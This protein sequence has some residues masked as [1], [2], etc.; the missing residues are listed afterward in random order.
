MQITHE[1]ARRFIQFDAD[2]ALAPEDKAALSVHLKNC[3]DCSTYADEV[4]AVE[5]ILSPVM[6]RQ[7]PF[8]PTPLPIAILTRSKNSKAPASIILTTRTALI[9]MIFL[10]LV[11][12]TWQFMVTSSW[13]P[14][15]LPLGVLPVPT[16][17]IQSTST[18]HVWENC[19]MS[20]YT[21]RE[22]DTLASIAHRF[23][24]SEETIMALNNIETEALT[25][26]ME[27]IIPRCNF[28]PTGTAMEPTLFQTTFTPLTSPPSSTPGG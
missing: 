6:K 4:K 5:R 9:S 22:N 25:I 11:F 19:E 10:G 20:S 21:V 7:W 15:Q 27:L 12:G 2:Q 18:K 28:T 14:G 17:S 16:P 3:S 23:S 1:E 13:E 8:E 24:I 26:S